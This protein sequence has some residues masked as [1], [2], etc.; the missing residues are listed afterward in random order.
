MHTQNHLPLPMQ[1]Q[2]GFASSAIRSPLQEV[3]LDQK[4]IESGLER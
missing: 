2:S 3:D 1:I 4:W